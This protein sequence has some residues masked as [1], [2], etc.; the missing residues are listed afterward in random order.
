MQKENNLTAAGLSSLVHVF[1]SALAAT[2]SYVP[3][4]DLDSRVLEARNGFTN[5]EGVR[6][7][8]SFLKDAGFELSLIHI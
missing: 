7:I 4:A 6:A 2:E 5:D 3:K 1:L 8:F